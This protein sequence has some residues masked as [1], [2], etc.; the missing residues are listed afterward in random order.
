MC[1]IQEWVL[2]MLRLIGARPPP[3]LLI[4]REAGD[5]GLRHPGRLSPARPLD[6]DLVC[7]SLATS[8]GPVTHDGLDVPKQL[9]ADP[10]DRPLIQRGRTVGEGVRP[11]IVR[12]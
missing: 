10:E 4:E 2:C 11:A 7:R 9:A 12:P 6:E 8:D 3:I 1:L 5:M